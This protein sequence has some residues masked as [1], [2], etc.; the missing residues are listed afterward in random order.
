ML[1]KHRTKSP[2]KKTPNSLPRAVIMAVVVVSSVPAVIIWICFAEANPRD[3]CCHNFGR[4][5][6]R[7]EYRESLQ[8]IAIGYPDRV[9][10]RPKTRAV[11]KHSWNRGVHSR[12]SFGSP[13]QNCCVFRCC[14]YVSTAADDQR[15]SKEN[16]KIM[17]VIHRKRP[18]EFKR[19]PQQNWISSSTANDKR[20]PSEND[21]KMRSSSIE[22]D[23][24]N[25]I[26]D[27]NNYIV[28]YNRQRE[29]IKRNRCHRHPQRTTKG[30][31]AKTTKN[32]CILISSLCRTASQRTRSSLRLD[33]SIIVYV[34]ICV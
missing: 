2:A 4:A 9:P 33:Q 8:S 26:E 31:Q 21:N 3:N 20:K 16:N 12:A 29:D 15:N 30:I 19:K 24:R 13:K 17:I 32:H 23:Q 11:L 7:L 25:S 14:N 34:Y 10:K 28:N 18:S 22:D 5:R 1:E 27:D 6:P